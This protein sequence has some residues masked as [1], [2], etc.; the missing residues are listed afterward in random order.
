[1]ECSEAEEGAVNREEKEP[2]MEIEA[3]W[4]GKS[5]KQERHEEKENAEEEKRE[6]KP[7]AAI[8][9]RKRW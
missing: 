8:R 6:R 9:R 5:G 1:M 4:P 7:E 3:I 2:G